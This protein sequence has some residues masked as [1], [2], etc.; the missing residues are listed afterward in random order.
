MYVLTF[1]TRIIVIICFYLFKIIIISFLLFYRA[2]LNIT[3]CEVSSLY[4]I[5]IIINRLFK[6]TTY[7]L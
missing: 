7:Q 4:K 5:I 3:F 1:L 6:I 2:S